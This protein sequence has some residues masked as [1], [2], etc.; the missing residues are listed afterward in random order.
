MIIPLMLQKRALASFDW[1]ILCLC[2]A[3]FAF[4]LEKP[5]E[6]LVWE[7]LQNKMEQGINGQFRLTKSV[8]KISKEFVSQGV[9]SVSKKDGI[10]WETEKPFPDINV[11]PIKKLQEY[12]SGDYEELLKKFDLKLNKSELADTLT[13]VPKE[14]SVKK[15]IASATLLV[16]GDY[17]QS[18]KIIWANSDYAFYEF[19][20]PNIFSIFP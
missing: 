11:F 14:R 5:A 17:L 16:K 8:A 12:F 4:G 13:L 9:F 19:M 20:V 2:F 6:H 10:I 3:S 1:A 18:C 15:I 7:K